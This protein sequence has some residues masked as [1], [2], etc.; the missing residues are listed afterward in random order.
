MAR[1]NLDALLSDL[2]AGRG[3]LL[4]PTETGTGGRPIPATYAY[5][6]GNGDWRVE[7]SYRG[8]SGRDYFYKAYDVPADGGRIPSQVQKLDDI[9]RTSHTEI[10]YGS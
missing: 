4:S 7:I 3:R 10:K 9:A 1:R 8:R 5:P 2:E 6:T